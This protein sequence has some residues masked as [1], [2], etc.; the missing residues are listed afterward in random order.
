MYQ[1]SDTNI[2]NLS[3]VI[4]RH[5]TENI[6]V[7]EILR[8]DRITI[9]IIED[10]SSFLDI[11]TEVNGLTP[12]NIL[13][14]LTQMMGIVA[15]YKYLTGE[16]KKRIVTILIKRKIL[17]LDVDPLLKKELIDVSNHVIPSAVDVLV[18][19]SKGT[20][21]FKYIPVVYRCIK[22]LFCCFCKK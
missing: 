12:E 4:T 15:K 6:N 19:V 3:T 13:L 21:K 9:D 18:E 2:E 5:S 17:E 20:Y 11:T 22:K 8:T 7:I 10:V 1:V 14:I 16:D